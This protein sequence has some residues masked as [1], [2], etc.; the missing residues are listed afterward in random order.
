MNKLRHLNNHSDI[1]SN[2]QNR[3]FI[4]TT[5]AILLPFYIGAVVL[6]VHFLYLIWTNRKKLI[7]Q[8]K[9][10]GW[11][12]V[13]ILYT[14]L[15]S[16]ENRNY[17]GLAISLALFLVAL[18]FSSYLESFSA[19]LYISLL[20]TISYGSFF[21]GIFNLVNYIIYIVKNNLSIFYILQT[22]NPQFRAEAT[23]FNANYYG[24]FCIFSILISIYLL[25]YT[26]EQRL[27][28]FHALI[29]SINLISIIMTAS[30]M[31]L[32]TVVIAIFV[33]V[34]FIHKRIALVLLGTGLLGL[35]GVMLFPT[36]FPRFETLAYGFEDRFGL[37]NTGWNIFLTKP[38]TGRG[39]LSYINFYYLFI[40]ETDMHA[41]QLLIDSLANYGLFGIF[42]LFNALFDYVN[43]LI[44]ALKISEIRL[45]VGLVLAFIVAVLVHGL[46]DVSIFW[47]QTGFVFLI[48]CLCPTES[49]LKVRYE[50]LK[51][52]EQD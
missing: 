42:I 51:K 21:V 4:M 31:L 6:I 46:V 48:V 44:E 43:R 49:M 11:I 36:L 9:E 52:L 2:R 29:I 3:L 8:I 14:A 7:Q 13:F 20:K 12:A 41:H 28:M 26:R 23:F 17:I 50:Q 22:S 47:L 40:N 45:E 25:N 37:W 30:R 38:L 27:R 24:L 34:F 5:V 32:P 10:M 18:Y 1:E 33:L 35:I 16:L 19:K 39:P 15:V